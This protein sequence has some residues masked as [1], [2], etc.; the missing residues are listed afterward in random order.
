MGS[1][2]KPVGYQNCLTDSLQESG[3]LMVGFAKLKFFA[4]PLLLVT[5]Y[6]NRLKKTMQG[7]LQ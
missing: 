3:F 5:A 1:S 2:N 4:V 6:R 7:T